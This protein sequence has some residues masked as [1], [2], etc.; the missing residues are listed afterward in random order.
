MQK[1]KQDHER[2]NKP[3]D[4]P[5]YSAEDNHHRDTTEAGMVLKTETRRK[6]GSSA[7]STRDV[8]AWLGQQIV[9]KGDI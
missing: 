6:E 3:K 7:E 5:K 4:E 1:F 9:K 8:E 2:E